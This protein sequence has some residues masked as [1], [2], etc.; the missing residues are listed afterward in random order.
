MK[1]KIYLHEPAKLSINDNLIQKEIKRN[2]LVIGNNLDNFRNKIV[3]INKSKFCSLVSS[4]TAALHL[5]LFCNQLDENCEVLL[6]AISFIASLNAILYTKAK[7]IFFD[8][9]SNLNLKFID[10]CNF[11]E[12][13]T[14]QDRNN[15]CINSKTKKH[16]KCILLIHVFGNIIDYSHLLKIS[17]K[18]NISIIEDAAESFGSYVKIKN[19]KFYSGSFGRFACFSF[20]GNKIIT[21]AG[22]GAVLS[23]SKKDQQLIDYYS[24]Q[25]KANPFTFQH[26]DIGFNYR[27]S[28]IHATL[29]FNQASS[30]YDIITKKRIIYD[31][32]KKYIDKDL[33]EIIKYD[34]GANY[35]L[36]VIKIFKEIDTLKLTKHMSFKNIEI[37]PVWFPLHLQKYAKKYQ[38]YK[39]KNANKVHKKYICL[40]SSISLTESKIKYICKT[41]R[42]YF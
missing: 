42:D 22:G 28:N 39:I 2:N 6:P 13:N 21:S 9:D 32:Y 7:P 27:L 25:A 16:I 1:N 34:E 12:K 30:F 23:N 3:Q 15:R 11:L 14:F 36:I 33:F 18:K 8:V 40:P 5:S 38:K 19:K 31:K 37:R 26:N 24:N 20:N 4:G 35:W 29:G 10:I 17:K 41:L